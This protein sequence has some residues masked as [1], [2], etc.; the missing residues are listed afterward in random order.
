[1][2]FPGAAKVWSI[3]SSVHSTLARPDLVRREN[4]FN[5]IFDAILG[6]AA[7]HA[8]GLFSLLVSRTDFSNLRQL[9]GHLSGLKRD[10]CLGLVV[11]KIVI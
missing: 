2:Q 10:L 8:D 6:H 1:V 11:A 4:K 7:S 9:S 5:K 3:Y